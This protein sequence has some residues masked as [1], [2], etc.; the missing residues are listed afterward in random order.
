MSFMNVG[1]FP[2]P[3]KSPGSIA[4]QVMCVSGNDQVSKVQ[5]NGSLNWAEKPHTAMER[6]Q[7]S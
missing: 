4:L 3:P 6:C 2:L 1:P 5:K 7:S